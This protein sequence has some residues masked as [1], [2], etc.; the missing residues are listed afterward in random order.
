[1]VSLR[2]PGL[3][4]LLG[5]ALVCILCGALCMNAVHSY[6]EAKEIQYE[7]TQIEQDVNKC[8]DVVHVYLSD[9]DTIMKQFADMESRF[10]R[11]EHLM[12]IPRSER[13]GAWKEMGDEQ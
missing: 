2:I 11:M 6:Y 9:R 3:A 13:H 4:I 5:F 10:T 7:F 12:H 1:M 8:A